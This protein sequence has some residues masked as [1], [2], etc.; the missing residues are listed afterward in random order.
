MVLVT[1][2][3][4]VFNGEAWLAEQLASVAADSAQP[5]Q[6]VIAD[7]G[8][9]DGSLTVARGF[10]RRMP[11]SIVDASQ[12]RGQAF[13]RNKGARAGSGGY[14]LFLD[15][16]DVIAPGYVQAM[17]TALRDSEIVAARMDGSMLNRGWRKY[18]RELAQK[19]GL[20]DEP[21]PWA[22]GCTLG[23][24]R[25]TFEQLGGFA[26]DLPA[27]A[28]EDVDFCWRAAERGLSPTI[29]PDAVVHYR[30]PDSVRGFF[31]QGIRYG[32]AGV[33]VEARHGVFND[34]T[35][36]ESVRSFLGPL[37]LVLLGPSLG[38]RGRGVFLLGRRIGTARGRHEVRIG[39]RKAGAGAALRFSEV[40]HA[41]VPAALQK[42][43]P[44]A[45]EDDLAEI[46]A[47][48]AIEASE[49]VATRFIAAVEKAFEPVRLLPLGGAPRDHLAPGCG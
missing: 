38:A 34:A 7:N 18:A 40:Q 49:A 11:L 27:P 30:F 24:R 22:Y 25:A 4:P 2:V 46:W 9:T 23:V 47:T 6:T 26:E 44:V 5:F 12:E 16:D 41:G 45:G 19:S 37:R 28:G 29:V 21:I 1:V 8:S 33:L 35:R 42:A 10:E 17:T 36:W 20:P 31:R 3:I 39:R 13:A 32:R 15:Q 48:I 14:L 43:D